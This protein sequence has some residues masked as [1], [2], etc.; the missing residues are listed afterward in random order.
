MPGKK[1][2]VTRKEFQE[3]YKRHYQLYQNSNVS[4]KTRRLILFYAVECGLKSLIMKNT[5]SGTSEEF[6]AYCQNNNKGWLFGHDIKAMMKEV[7][8]N[9]E[10]TLRHIRLKQGDRRVHPRE[11]NQIWRY[12]ATVADEDEEKR[13]EETLEKIAD[14]IQKRI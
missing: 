8:P 6:E 1:I 7:N 12:G 3:S 14:W 13:A 11:F 9:S 5:N 2:N 4:D 10:Y